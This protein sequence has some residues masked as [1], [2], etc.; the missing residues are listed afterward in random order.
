MGV[1]TELDLLRLL[2]NPDTTAN[3]VQEYASTNLFTVNEDEQLPNVV[4][5]FLSKPFR[6]V[7]VVSDAGKLVGV[8]SRRDV[9]RAIRDVRVKVNS[10]L[11]KRRHQDLATL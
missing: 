3:C 9:I 8:V 2:Y 1:I 11:E 6:R 5:I 4:E 10:V 7:P